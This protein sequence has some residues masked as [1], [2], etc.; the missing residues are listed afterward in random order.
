MARKYW[1]DGASEYY[2]SFSKAAFVR[3]LQQLVPE[4]VSSDLV[5]DGSGVRA[6]AR[7]P[8]WIAGGRLSIRSIGK[9][10]ARLECSLAR[11]NRV[12]ADRTSY[13]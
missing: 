11:R 12:P 4:I 7:S 5:A 1:R 10:V 9:D 2:R 13:R 3:A 8:G 6:Q